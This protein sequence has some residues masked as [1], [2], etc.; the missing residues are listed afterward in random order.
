M[1]AYVIIDAELHK[2]NVIQENV[3]NHSFTNYLGSS[4]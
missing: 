4:D 3:I 2:E 1:L